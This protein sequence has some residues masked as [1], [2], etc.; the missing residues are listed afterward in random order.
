MSCEGRERARKGER[1]RKRAAKGASKGKGRRRYR[2][3][4]SLRYTGLFCAPGIISHVKYYQVL[5][6]L[7]RRPPAPA[8][9]RRCAAS[10]PATLHQSAPSDTRRMARRSQRAT[11][12]S[13][14]AARSQRRAVSASQRQSAIGKPKEISDLRRVR[15]DF[16]CA[17]PHPG[18]AAG[19]Q[20]DFDTS[21]GRRPKIFGDTRKTLPRKILRTKNFF[22]VISEA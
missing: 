14:H 5:H 3:G 16:G 18:R 11:R 1:A 9:L 6:R 19:G 2:Q 8:R 17:T 4:A 15:A 20:D 10:Q 21:T 22:A 13:Q 12:R 7:T